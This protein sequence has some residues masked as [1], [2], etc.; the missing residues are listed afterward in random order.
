MAAPFDPASYPALTQLGVGLRSLAGDASY[1][2]G[3]DYLRKGLVKH[4]AVA[5]SEAG[6][7]AYATVSGSTDYRVSVSLGAADA[8]VTC[9]CPAHR[10]NKYCKHVVALCVALGERAGDFAVG[11]APPEAQAAPKRAPRAKGTKRAKA[12]D[13]SEAERRESGLT[14]VDR[15]LDELADG[16]LAGLGPDKVALLS[17]AADLVRALKLRRLGNLL[18]ALRHAAV[19]DRASLEGGGFARL[20]ADLYT[21][22]RATGAHLAGA[23]QMD[24]ELA[25]DLLGRTWRDDEL[26]PVGGLALLEVGATRADDGEFRVETSYLADM[27]TGKLYAERQITPSRLRAQ[28]KAR[29]RHLLA[30]EHALLF[31]GTATRRIRLQRFRHEPLTA[32]DV[33]RLVARLPASAAHA[34]AALVERLSEPFGATEAPVVFCPAALLMREGR[35]SAVDAA[36]HALELECAPRWLEGLAPLLPQAGEYAL[37]GVM[38]LADDGP[39]LHCVSAVSGAFAWSDGPLYPVKE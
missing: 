24:A 21:T 8:K 30:V 1:A 39:R 2:A 18:M 27:A 14:T 7:T 26:E 17:R 13:P 29:H 38:R 16:G 19:R 6:V 12:S 11:E 9:T 10:R 25:E 37:F 34:R 5:V 22:R 4:G 28:P 15:L 3:R 32:E 31:P 20:L 33:S 23:A 35:R 36:G